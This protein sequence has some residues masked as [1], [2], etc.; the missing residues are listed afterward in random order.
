MKYAWKII[1]AIMLI[2]LAAFLIYV[3]SAMFDEFLVTTGWSGLEY[4]VNEDGKTCTV[5]GIGAYKSNILHLDGTVDG[6]PVTAIGDSAFENS[7]L[8]FVYLPSSLKMI[9]N[10]A[11]AGCTSLISVYNI[12]DCRHLEHIGDYAFENCS[13]I[14]E[15]LLSDSVVSIGEFAFSKCYDLKQIDLPDN[16]IKIGAYA[17]Q[18]CV[19]LEEVVLPNGLKTIGE[20]AFESCRALTKINIPFST[21]SIETMAFSGCNQLTN[22]SVDSDNH[23]YTSI[24]GHLYNSNATTLIQT[25]TIGIDNDFVVPEGVNRIE[26]Y[27]LRDLPEI[28]SITIPKSVKQFGS[29][30]V[31][32]TPK[33]TSINYEGTVDEWFL[34]FK[35]P[36]W[37]EGSANFTIY[38]TDGMIDK[39]GTV[40]Y[41]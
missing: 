13:N 16:L 8:K 24:D 1:S 27:A 39:D 29:W 31:Y 36:D 20:S 10:R 14:D 38:C 17:F 41:K 37:N 26:S 19:S 28:K 7:N 23:F 32:N 34:I 22:I 2:L 30:I 25:S 33:L 3:F 35:N 12:E 5:T 6:Y 21:E 18:G 11:F 4:S 40:T 9:G 15:I